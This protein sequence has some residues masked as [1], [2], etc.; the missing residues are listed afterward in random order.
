MPISDDFY[1]VLLAAKEIHRISGGAWDGTLEPIIDLW[2]FGPSGNGSPLLSIP[3][4]SVIEAHLKHVGFDQI[5]ISDDRTIRKKDPHITLDLNSIAKGYAADR[6]AAVLM[7]NG[8]DSL[9]AEIGGETV[10]KGARMDGKP[11]RV[12]INVPRPDAAV[13]SI[14]RVLTLKDQGLATSG[15]YRNFFE[16]D[17]VRHSH[18]FDPRTGYPVSNRIASVSVIA[19]TC[20]MADGLA[21]ALMVLGVDKGLALVSTLE[22]IECMLVASE[23]DGRLTDCSSQGFPVSK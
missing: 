10:A 22:G 17:G 9:L 16:I 13:D 23:P 18:V 8:V 1:R 6:V 5:D 21:T 3:S 14:Y 19:P 12:G 7:A 11:W 4:S 15:D 2:G 20:A